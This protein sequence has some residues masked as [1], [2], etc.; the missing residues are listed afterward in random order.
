MVAALAPRASALRV[1]SGGA[2]G[3]GP[4]FDV[5]R[6]TATG[7][8]VI[9]GR[10][11]PGANVV[12]LD[13]GN[14]LGEAKANRRGEW[15]L[16]PLKPLP[17]GATELYIEASSSGVSSR[18]SE[19]VVVLSVPE[20]DVS[21]PARVTPL[22]V[23]TPR[24]GGPTR[25]LQISKRPVARDEGGPGVTL[26]VVD[27]DDAGNIVLSGR[28]DANA[29][30]RVYTDNRLVGTA[31]SDEKGDWQLRPDV[32]IAPGDHELRVDSVSAD[33]KVRARAILPFS[34]ADLEGSDLRAGRV[35]VQPG[36]SLWRIARATY[37]AGNQYTLIYDANRD[38]IGDPHLIFPGQVFKVPESN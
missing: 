5:V 33:G 30:V 9:A 34:R 24:G 32:R 19:D 35:I 2:E 16:V 13:R 10:A 15:V 38:Q 3:V 27:Y 7:N 17:P 6:I 18:R 23:L 28:A 22:A 20:R 8:A 25:V 21:Q 31:R 14:A 12:V 4:T 1:V 36:N 29:E 37:G 11:A 26:D